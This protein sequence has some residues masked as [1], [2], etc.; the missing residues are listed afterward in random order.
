MI[1]PPR[2]IPCVFYRC[3][4]KLW[5]ED[6]LSLYE[7]QEEKF[8]VVL[9]SGKETHFY[10]WQGKE[11]L[12]LGK[13][14]SFIRNKQGRGGSAQNRF[15]RLREGELVSYA[16]R[17][18]EEAK[19]LFQEGSQ[20]NVAS[21]FLIGSKDKLGDISL[22]WPSPL[23]VHGKIVGDE[24]SMA[25][26]VA[27]KVLEWRC[28]RECKVMN[29]FMQAL[30]DGTAIYGKKQVVEAAKQ[31]LLKRRFCTAKESDDS[32]D[33]YFKIEGLCSQTA[34]F[35]SQFPYGGMSFYKMEWMEDQE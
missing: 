2:S 12:L 23:Q 24:K 35:I 11:K 18:K 3:D 25:E 8:G 7:K 31:N 10:S 34:T 17:I 29:D 33:E 14:T 19:R 6:I 30:H 4:K 27:A 26:L 13:I 9:I 16:S 22:P 15:E 21:I 20:M 28:A 32:F 5:V 1:Y